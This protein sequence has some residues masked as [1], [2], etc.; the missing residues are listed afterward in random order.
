MWEAKAIGLVMWILTCYV[1]YSCPSLS[2]FYFG[3]ILIG[4]LI[5]LMGGC[6]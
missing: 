1:I 3:L 5:D 2:V 6:P 4:I